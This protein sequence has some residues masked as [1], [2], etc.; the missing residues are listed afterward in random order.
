MKFDSIEAYKKAINGD[1]NKK[2]VSLSVPIDS[3][4]RMSALAKKLKTSVSDI[5]VRGGLGFVETDEMANKVDSLTDEDRIRLDL[6][7]KAS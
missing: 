7:F 3:H 6:F 4:N 5:Y 2:T 1:E